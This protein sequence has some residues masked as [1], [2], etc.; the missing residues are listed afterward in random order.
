[1]IEILNNPWITG[2]GGGIVS[3]LIVFFVTKYLF[4]KK[5]N[6]EYVQKIRTANNEILYSIRPLIIEKKLPSVEILS[7]IRISIA[8]KYGIKQEDLYNDFSLSNDLITEIM[9]NS[10]LSS[11]Q[12]LEFCD[13]L[14]QMKS[15]QKTK[16][17][18]EVVYIQERNS[19]SS[20]YSSMLLALS[21]FG[22]V[23]ISTQYIAKEADKQKFSFFEENISLLLIATLTPILAM[24]IT[25]LY[26][27]M[28][29]ERTKDRKIAEMLNNKDEKEEDNQ[30]NAPK[31]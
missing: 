13:L 22:M 29:K 5:E 30:L 11:E 6:R 2:I 21:S 1:M 8:K 16:D 9:G 24:T 3:S 23:L 31:S 15:K 14:N 26:K 17:E 18:I 19:L 28:I 7:A 25:L 12:K 10:F 27:I 4:S 20:K